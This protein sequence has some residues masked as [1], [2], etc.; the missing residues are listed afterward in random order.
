MRTPDELLASALEVIEEACTLSPRVRHFGRYLPLF[1]GGY[2][3][4]CA[5]YCASQHARFK[6]YVYHIDTGIGSTK[7][8]QYVD[9]VCD[10]FDWKLRVFKSAETYESFVKKLGFPG[11]GAHH[12]IYA[13]IKER[14]I[15]EMTDGPKPSILI[16][17]CRSHESTRRMGHVEP[18][19]P[20]PAKSSRIWIAP[21]HDWTDEE[22][23]QF[24]RYHSFP[25]NPVKDSIIG[26]SGECFC[27]AFARPNELQMIE[28]VCPE[29]YAEIKRLE[30]VAK[31]C[32]I[33]EE[34]AKWGYRSSNRKPIEV[35]ETG[36]LCSSC[37]R[38]AQAAGVVF[39][40][41]NEK[42]PPV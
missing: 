36:P 29:V 15:R 41:A 20:D 4:L 37:D 26:M 32:G 39:V 30:G 18:I 5:C 14:C 21:C 25:R 10:E 17:G 42:T 23:V 2:D 13:R 24:V 9:G 31:E 35:V 6:G 22:Q 8:R 12:W 33:N 27:G 38:K 19:K 40:T 16:T 3:S 1:S 34:S 7:T 28:A 11:P